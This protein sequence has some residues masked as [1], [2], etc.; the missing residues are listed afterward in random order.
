MMRNGMDSVDEPRVRLKILAGGV[1]LFSA[2]NA[3]GMNTSSHIALALIYTL[4]QC[5]SRVCISV[6]NNEV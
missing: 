3:S 6:L 1:F 5:V 4:H 2:L